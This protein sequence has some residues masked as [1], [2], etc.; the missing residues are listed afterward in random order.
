MTAWRQFWQK[1]LLFKPR[2]IQ[3]K[4]DQEKSCY[5]AQARSWSED[6][7]HNL[8][9]SRTRHQ[10]ALV[11]LSAMMALLLI[12]LA[13][14][15]H[16]QKMAVVVIHQSTSGY[17]WVSVLNHHLPQPVSWP[18]TRAEIARYIQARQSYDPV[19]YTQQTDL[20]KSMSSDQVM[21]QYL[22]DESSHNPQSPIH[23]LGAG[24]YRTC[25]IQSIIP[26][27]QAMNA[28]RSGAAYAAQ[29]EFSIQDHRFGQNA[30]KQSTYKALVHWHHRGIPSEPD[31][32]IKN[33]DGFEI[34]HFWMTPIITPTLTHQGV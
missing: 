6:H 29:V 17:S 34:T 13:C 24:G 11:G 15:I 18:Q 4:A 7:Y 9:L 19:F 2:N 5:Y 27:A 14:W 25:Q 10:W 16:W 33:W 12:V 32:M 28:S 20:V 31:L 21:A 8:Y 22:A 1:I 26:M 23:L 3:A 30:D